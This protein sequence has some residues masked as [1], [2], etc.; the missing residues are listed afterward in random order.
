M[1]HKVH[2]GSNTGMYFVVLYHSLARI[3]RKTVVKL[4]RQTGG[5]AGASGASGQCS[6]PAVADEQ[7]FCHR[8]RVPF[9]IFCLDDYIIKR[10]RFARSIPPETAVARRRVCAVH[11]DRPCRLPVRGNMLH[12]AICRGC[13]FRG[14]NRTGL[15]ISCPVR[16][17]VSERAWRS[18]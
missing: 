8:I 3:C 14:R 12:T 1:L 9:W 4:N 13:G 15:Q 16:C 2:P 11:L 5:N 10:R 18:G 6:G 7:Y 17:R